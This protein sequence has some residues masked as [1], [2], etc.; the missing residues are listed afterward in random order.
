MR[1][2]FNNYQRERKETEKIRIRLEPFVKNL[3][4]TSHWYIGII[5][6]I[7]IASSCSKTEGEMPS[8]LP[9]LYSIFRNFLTKSVVLEL[10]RT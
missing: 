2:R 10:Q 4:I 5:I 1:F 8:D 9:K 6:R 7:L 3:N